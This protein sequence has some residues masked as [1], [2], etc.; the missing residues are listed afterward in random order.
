VVAG[1]LKGPEPPA[2][3]ATSIP[4]PYGTGG[5]KAVGVG[6]QHGCI[7]AVHRRHAGQPGRDDGRRQSFPARYPVIIVDTGRL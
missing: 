4:V 7:D 2:V 5:L 6:P 3:K 1:S